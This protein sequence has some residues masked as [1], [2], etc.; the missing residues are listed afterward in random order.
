MDYENNRIFNELIILKR[1]IF[2]FIM[3]QIEHNNMIKKIIRK[4]W[5]I[6]LFIFILSLMYQIIFILFKEKKNISIF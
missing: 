5:Y 2:I 1:N 3:D 6:Y 4:N